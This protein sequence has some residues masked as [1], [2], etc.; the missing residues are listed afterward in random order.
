M[1]QYSFP[2]KVLIIAEIGV[3]HN[4]SEK[5]AYKMIDKAKTCGADIVKFQ[6][7]KTDKFQVMRFVKGEIVV[8]NDGEQ[9][10]V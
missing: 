10:M 4:G 7:F 6:L 1:K 5:L 9:G 2:K 3:N 8:E